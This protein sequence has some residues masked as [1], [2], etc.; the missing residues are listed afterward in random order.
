L[1]RRPAMIRHVK[2]CTRCQKRKP[3]D[4]FGPRTGASDGRKSQC[5]KCAAAAARERRTTGRTTGTTGPPSKGEQ[6]PGASVIR[7]FDRPRSR[8][9][10]SKGTPKGPQGPRNARQDDFPVPVARGPRPTKLT[11][12]VQARIVWAIEGGNYYEDAARWARID[13]K[14]FRRW[15]QQGREQESGILRDFF[16]AVQDA[17]SH[18]VVRAV[19]DWREAWG[20]D[21]RAA[22]A[23]LAR[24]HPERWGDK[25]SSEGS[26]FDRDNWEEPI[27]DPAVID[28][29]VA[30]LEA[31]N[32]AAA[33]ALDAKIEALLK[34]RDAANALP[35]PPPR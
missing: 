19:T 22:A 15:M 12:E 35:P 3:L 18:A 10:G 26:G 17:D 27:D 23:F 4:A 2:V 34:Q 7:I 21:W 32:R 29:A 1:P 33:P 31:K 20:K 6:K 13:P 28:A 8:A 11:P 5:K 30:F 24:R 16:E 25:M 14:T 9:G